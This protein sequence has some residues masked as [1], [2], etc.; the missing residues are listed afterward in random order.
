MAPQRTEDERDSKAVPRSGAA[1]RTASGES[2]KIQSLKRAAAILD[3]VARRP[4]GISLAQL[5]AE[6]D[7][8]NST[9]FHLIQTLVGLGFLT[10]LAD[11]RRYRIGTRLFTLAA[12]ALDE[13]ALFSLGT[14][15]LERLSAETGHAA[16]LAVRSKQE[17]IVIAR[18]A[19]SG[20]LQLAGHP[21]ATRPAHATAIGKMLLAAMPPEDLDRVLATLPMPAFTPNTLTDRQALRREIDEVRRAGIAHDNCELDADVRCIAVP[22]HDFA[23]RC[24]A[25]MGLSGPAWR[26]S[27][28]ILQ[29]KSRQLIAAAAELSAQLGS[30]GSQMSL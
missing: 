24:V 4:E 23:G 17:I 26:L 15:I 12:G 28:E 18:T 22:V 27:P 5:S 7:L 16:H 19:A 29:E 6:L 21:G 11:S 25:A 1:R 9:A 8:R 20:L 10:Q 2:G 3:A 14:P 30:G 13:T